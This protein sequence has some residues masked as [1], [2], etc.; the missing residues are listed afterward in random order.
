[1]GIQGVAI[2]LGSIALSDLFGDANARK[3]Y[4]GPDPPGPPP[5]AGMVWM[6]L[7]PQDDDDG[8]EDDD[9]YDDDDDGGGY[10]APT[11]AS[12]KDTPNPTKNPV[13]APVPTPPPPSPTPKISSAEKPT[14][15]L[16]E[17]VVATTDVAVSAA[18]AEQPTTE[19]VSGK[20]T[21]SAG[22]FGG[23]AAAVAALVAAA[24]LLAKKRSSSSQIDHE[25]YPEDMDDYDFDDVPPPPPMAA[26]EDDIEIDERF[27]QIED[28]LEYGDD[29]DLIED[30]NTINWN[31]NDADDLKST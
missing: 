14:P 22:A 12:V 26:N 11:P 1:M 23:I 24:V 8:Y 7:W 17:D 2:L 19:E 10:V 29:D 28:G 20:S 25:I 16:S 15:K 27:F 30:H 13:P 18:L 9:G 21:L 6:P 31:S 3:L 4:Y 5:E